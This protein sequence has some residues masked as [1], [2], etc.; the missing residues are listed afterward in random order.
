MSAFH[1][2]AA[3]ERTSQIV[4]LVPI[5]AD[6]APRA[7]FTGAALRRFYGLLCRHL[8]RNIGHG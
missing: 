3:E 2:T 4:R 1:P 5:I 7:A 8:H 6:I